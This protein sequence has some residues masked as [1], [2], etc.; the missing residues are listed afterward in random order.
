MYESVHFAGL[1]LAYEA[2]LDSYKS[3]TI[4]YKKS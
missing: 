2:L 1:F 3:P 4:S